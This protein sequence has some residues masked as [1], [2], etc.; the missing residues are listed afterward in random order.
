MLPRLQDRHGSSN[1]CK[2][3]L[4]P[5]SLV[6]PR[7][8]RWASA[9]SHGLSTRQTAVSENHFQGILSQCHLPVCFSSVSVCGRQGATRRLV[10]PG[11]DGM[12]FPEG[13]G[14]L[15]SADDRRVLLMASTGMLKM[16]FQEA[17]NYL[18]QLPFPGLRFG[19]STNICL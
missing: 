6:C 4:T 18:S 16:H 14:P 15:K 12:V 9:P 10:V 11:E 17:Q 1:F 8:P 5:I 2:K 19:G 3:P 13:P 7:H